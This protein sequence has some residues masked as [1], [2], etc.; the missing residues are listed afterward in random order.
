[1]LERIGQP[2]IDVGCRSGQPLLQGHGKTGPDQLHCRASFSHP[3]AYVPLLPENASLE[4]NTARLARL[5]A[6][7]LQQ[8]ERGPEAAS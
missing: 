7:D 3:S 4:I 2:L 8:A 5:L 1:V 6:G